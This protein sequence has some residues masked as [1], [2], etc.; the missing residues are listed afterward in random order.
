MSA[1]R[2]ERDAVEVS[3]IADAFLRL[4]SDFYDQTERALSLAPHARIHILRA[5]SARPFGLPLD[6]FAELEA[7]QAAFLV[8]EDRSSVR[9]VPSCFWI[10]SAQLRP[11]LC[12][13]RGS[14]RTWS[15]STCEPK[16]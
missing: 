12:I 9:S 4:D 6:P 3:A 14:Q 2:G 10:P 11:L 7:A 5:A 1:S 16:P 8:P 15:H 13:A